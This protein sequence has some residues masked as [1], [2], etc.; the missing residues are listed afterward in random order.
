MRERPKPNAVE[1]PLLFATVNHRLHKGR[2]F[3]IRPPDLLRHVWVIGKTGMGKSTLLETL[4]VAQM[5]AGHGAGLIDPHGDLAERVIGQVPRHRR[6]DL[7]VIDPSAPGRKASLN[8]VGYKEPAD[9]PLAAA[10]ALSVLKK[11]FDASWGPRTEHVV[12]NSVLALLDTPRST[13]RGILHLAS[14]ERFRAMAL[15]HVRDPLVRAFWEEEFASLP[16]AF[17]AE[18]IAPVQNK[19]GALLSNPIIRAHV[20]QPKVMLSFRDL[21]DRERLVIVN[22]SKGRIGED[23]SGFL[24]SLILGAFQ[25]AA[26]SRASVPLAKRV[27]FTLYVDEFQRFVTPSFAELLAE[28]RKFGMGLVLANQNLAQLDPVLRGALL[29]NAGTLIAFRLSAD[30]ALE[31]EPEFVPE[32]R[33]HDLARLGRHE[34]ALKLA[35]DGVTSVPFTARTVPLGRTM[36]S[37]S[38]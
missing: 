29:G 1:R 33:A 34:I 14:D 13:L 35:V 38:S 31:L 24:G 5:D 6:N 15:R 17:R 37:E 21:M 3:G 11:T 20:D 18:V 32:L 22:L 36:Y 2:R 25:V 28:S 7:L 16:P 8:L 30:D 27:P 4:F 9:R 26:Y 23:A 12:R 10:A 19:V